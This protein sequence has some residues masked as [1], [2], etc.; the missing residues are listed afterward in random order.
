MSSQVL[1]PSCNLALGLALW[2]RLEGVV[3]KYNI[4]DVNIYRGLSQGVPNTAPLTGYFYC[5]L[6]FVDEKTQAQGGKAICPKTQS[7][8]GALGFSPGV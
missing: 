7:S 2:S 3:L 4:N 5:H 6:C 1:R 8:K